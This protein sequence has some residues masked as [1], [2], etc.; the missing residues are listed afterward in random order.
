[1]MIIKRLIPFS[2]K[3]KKNYLPCLKY[4][5][6]TLSEDKTIKKHDEKGEEHGGEEN[7]KLVE[8]KSERFSSKENKK[9]GEEGGIFMN[10]QFI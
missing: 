6:S 3:D 9:C 7:K 4:R 10:I 8:G 1:M 2:N 5:N